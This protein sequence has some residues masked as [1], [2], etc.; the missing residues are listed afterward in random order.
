MSEH[1]PARHLWRLTNGYEI[2]VDPAGDVATARGVAHHRVI[3]YAHGEL[4]QLHDPETEVDHLTP[5]PWLNYEANLEGVERDEHARRTRA[6]H[7]SRVRADGGAPWGY[8]KPE[9]R[10]ER[11]SAHY[12]SAV[13]ATV[14]ADR[15]ACPYCEPDAEDVEDEDEGGEA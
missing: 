3:A 13:G 7:R 11:A 2:L 9:K 4:D 14:W 12:C 1:P 10:A 6:R 8:E 15:L 5:V